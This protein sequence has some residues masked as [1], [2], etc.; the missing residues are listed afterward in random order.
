MHPVRIIG[1]F[2]TVGLLYGIAY[3]AIGGLKKRKEEPVWKY[4]HS[5]DWMFF[6]LLF[7]TTLTG[8]FV[9]VFKYLHLPMPTY[10]TYTIHLAV[11]MPL[12]VLEVPFAKWS[13]LAYRPFAIYFARLKE[14]VQSKT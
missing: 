3:M 5:T 9:D 14:Y 7:L 11:V 8:L 12:L 6:I 2:A 13:H 4:S 10:I 1:Y